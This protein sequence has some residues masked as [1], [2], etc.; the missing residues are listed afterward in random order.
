MHLFNKQSSLL[1]VAGA[2]AVLFSG[3]AKADGVRG[4]AMF[5][6]SASVSQD[7]DISTVTFTSP[8]TVFLT[9]GDYSS[10]PN[11]TSTSFA[12]VSWTG[13][14][15]SAVLAS[16]NTPEWTIVLAGTTYQFSIVS[17]SSAIAIAAQNAVSVT[18]LGIATISGAINREP[19]YLNFSLQAKDNEAFF[20]LGQLFCIPGQCNPP[21]RLVPEASSSIVLLVLACLA[22]QIVRWT[23][24]VR[25]DRPAYHG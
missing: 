16:N 3:Y 19:T 25:R 14:G 8:M 15:S 9:T 22:L 5:D 20:V 23:T 6:G 17:L 1:P 10:I 13:S 12:P 4:G 21:P 11:G 2:I 24:N 18:G 7:G